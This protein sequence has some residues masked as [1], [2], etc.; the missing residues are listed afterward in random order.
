MPRI[1]YNADPIVIHTPNIEIE[2]P[3]E[4]P[5]EK[6]EVPQLLVQPE[7]TLRSK[8]KRNVKPPDRLQY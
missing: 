4:A 8:P 7:L 3:V 5:A 6:Q 1:P 2:T